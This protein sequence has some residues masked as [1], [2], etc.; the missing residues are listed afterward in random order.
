MEGQLHIVLWILIALA[1][2]V[3]LTLLWQKVIR[4]AFFLGP[5]LR[6]MKKEKQ[7]LRRGEYNAAMVKGRQ[8]FEML[9]NLVAELNG[10]ELDNTAQA[11][12]NAKNEQIQRN[13]NRNA[14]RGRRTRNVMTYQQFSHWL[15]EEGYL[16]RVAKWELNQVRIIGNKA[17]HENYSSKEEA[18]NQYRYLEDLLKILS[19]DRPARHK[20]QPQR[21]RTNQRNGKQNNTAKKQPA[22]QQQPAQKNAQ[23][24]QAQNQTAKQQEE[25]RR[26]KEERRLAEQQ[27]QEEARKR[28]E[29]R[30]LA[31]QK[32]QEDARKRKEERRLAE[33]KRQEDARKRKEERRLAEQKR[34]EEAKK[35][36][37]AKAQQAKT[38][39]A[40]T[41][42]VQKEQALSGSDAKEEKQVQPAK[43]RRRRRKP[44][45]PAANTK[46]TKVL[47]VEG[48]DE[49]L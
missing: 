35:R 4:R 22:K 32:R 34:Q 27:R 9:L 12:A 41:Q 14:N 15:D 7:W 26:L 21:N 46:N 10:I 42:Q 25:A 19:E 43:K 47:V 16:D 29:E 33:Q 18:W 13:T 49:N 48:A 17:V 6:E 3:A 23:Q 24:K 30:R 40:K 2:G 36:K 1:A 44:R 39:Q 38:Q 5:V 45:K 20:K 37:E 28:K 31:E 8:N 11:V